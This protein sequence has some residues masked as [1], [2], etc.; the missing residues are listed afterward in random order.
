[1]YDER[2]GGRDGQGDPHDDVAGR[3]PREQGPVLRETDAA[4]ARREAREERMRT[5]GDAPQMV[6]R[7]RLLAGV[8]GLAFAAGFAKLVDYQVLNVDRYRAEANARRLYSQ[9]LYAKRGTIYDRNGNVLASS[10]DCKNVFVNA[11][12]VKKP[13]EAAAALSSVLGLDEAKMLT[14]ITKLKEKKSTFYYIQRQVDVDDAEKLRKKNVAGIEF[15]DAVKRM[16]P[17]GALASQVLGVVNIDNKGI[18]GIEGYYNSLLSG[19][20]GSIVRERG[21]DG[22]YIAGGAYQKDPAKDGSDIVLAIDA[23]IQRAAED[24]MAEAVKNAGATYGSAVVC[25]PSTGEILAACSYPTYDQSNLAEARNEDMNLRVV[26]DAY[27]PGSV[28]KTL[29]AGAA[30]DLG[31]LTPDSTFDVPAR[32]KVGDSYVSDVDKRGVAM[33]MTLREIIRRSSN[34]GMV[35]VGR[36]IGADN[37]SAY[38]KKW[39]ICEPSGVDFSGENGGILQRRDQYDGSSLGSMS[40]GQGLAVAPIEMLRAATGL[41]NGGVMKTPHFLKAKRGREVDWSAD[42]TRAIG[43]EAAESVVAMMETVVSEGTGKPAAISGY[44]IAGKTGTAER[45][46]EKNEDGTT[47]NMA[48]FL[49]FTSPD[50]PQAMVYITLDGTEYSSAMA[51]PPFKTIMQS[52]ISALGIKPEG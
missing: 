21:R 34:V 8:F 6:T 47:K 17:Y 40:F 10:I 3:F 41:A 7:R 30:I 49:G 25:D 39:K 44:A 52:A 31:I 29:V 23:N 20:D 43:R 27:E 13:A 51:M 24:A 15:E 5:A 12:L 36:E 22:S 45:L 14:T 35:L 50:N 26:T 42:D 4:R 28:F 9:K 19:T 46:G 18:S 48:S 11:Q 37:F 1:M 16:Y 38:L 32:I 2:Y 33:T